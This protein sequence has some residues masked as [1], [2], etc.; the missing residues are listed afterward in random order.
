MA[1]RSSVLLSLVR[2][3][4]VGTTL[5]QIRSAIHLDHFHHF[6]AMTGA[7]KPAIPESNLN[8]DPEDR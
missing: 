8:R 5:V 3:H 4:H 2:G 6:M 1:G 7:W